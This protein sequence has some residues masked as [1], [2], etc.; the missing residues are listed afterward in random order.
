MARRWWSRCGLEGTAGRIV[1]VAAAAARRMTTRSRGGSSSC[2]CDEEDRSDDSGSSAVDP[3][4][5]SC[6]GCRFS[7]GGR[8]TQQQGET[9]DEKVVRFPDRGNRK[10]DFASP[11]WPSSRARSLPQNLLTRPISIPRSSRA[12]MRSGTLAPRSWYPSRGAERERPRR[13][14]RGRRGRIGSVRT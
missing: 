7:R 14:G 1:R 6:A 12:G 11:S 9:G 5:V 3:E 4:Q 2:R 13:E 8:R 10:T